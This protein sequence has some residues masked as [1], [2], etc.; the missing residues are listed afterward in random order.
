MYLSEAEATMRRTTRPSDLCSVP[1]A[2]TRARMNP[3]TIWKLIRQGKLRA[4]GTPGRLRVCVA[5][6]LPEY[7][8]KGRLSQ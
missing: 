6:L 4:Y 5:D 8:P 7:E 2:A 3:F 1:E